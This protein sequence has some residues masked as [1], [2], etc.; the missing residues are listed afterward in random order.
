[1]HFIVDTAS[2]DHPFDPEAES[3]RFNLNFFLSGGRPCLV[4]WLEVLKAYKKWLTF[5]QRTKSI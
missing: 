3:F 4:V 5:V 1:M 2:G